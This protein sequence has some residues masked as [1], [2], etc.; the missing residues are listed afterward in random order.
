MSIS[1]PITT[2][3]K[4]LYQREPQF[5]IYE[6]CFWGTSSYSYQVEGGIS[7]NDCD[8][9][10]RSGPIKKRISSLTTKVELKFIYSLP[11]KQSQVK[12]MNLFFIIMIYTGNVENNY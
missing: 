9:F 5:A 4:P 6:S 3:I 12:I 1:S 8:Y 2:I 7:N 10:A 11:G